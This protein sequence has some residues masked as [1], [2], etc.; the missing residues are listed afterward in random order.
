MIFSRPRL[1]Q[2]AANLPE[3]RLEEPVDDDLEIPDEGTPLEV[4]ESEPTDHNSS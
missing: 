3:E 2:A 1:N 4:D